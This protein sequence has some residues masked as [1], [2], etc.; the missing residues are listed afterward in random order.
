MSWLKAIAHVLSLLILLAVAQLVTF[1]G[2]TILLMKYVGTWAG[3]TY[4]GA[5]LLLLIGLMVYAVKKASPVL[6]GKKGLF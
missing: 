5:F 1:I 4:L 6:D 2:P 3:F